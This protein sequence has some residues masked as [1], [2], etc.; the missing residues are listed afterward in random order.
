MTEANL[1]RLVA[2]WQAWAADADHS[3]DGWQSDFPEWSRLIESAA[4]VMQRADS[5]PALLRLVEFCWSISEEGEELLE[6][7]RRTIS[8]C[9]PVV[10]AMSESPL[11]ACRWQAYE[12]ATAAGVKAEPLVRAGLS[13]PAPY[14]RRRA[15][16]A[17]ARLAPSD[18]ATVASSLLH[19]PDPY[20]RQAAI[21]LVSVSDDAAFKKSAFETLSRDDV[22][23]V[24]AA[25]VRQLSC[26]R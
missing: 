18:A 1:E 20:I 2:K 26:G 16:L 7:A 17:L 13:D 6:I 14:A 19:D 9:W 3:E 12:A 4:E 11:P 15:V 5:D 21:E 24:R 25:A 10:V 23:H 22:D 8:S